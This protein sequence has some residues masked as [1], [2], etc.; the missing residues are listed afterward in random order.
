MEHHKNWRVKT[1]VTDVTEK[2]FV[3][4]IDTW[5]DSIL[6]SAT[7]TWVAYPTGMANVSSGSYRTNY[8]PNH[9]LPHDTSERVNF[10]N[11]VFTTVPRVL[12]AL[13]SINIDCS[14]DLRLK[15]YSTHVTRTGMAVHVDNW[16]N[17]IVYNTGVSYIALAKFRK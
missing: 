12:V 8:P 10:D 15:V 6:N 14:Q 2:K 3:I 13:N 17:S 9:P 4:H 1:Y 5:D 16:A 11:G 7:A